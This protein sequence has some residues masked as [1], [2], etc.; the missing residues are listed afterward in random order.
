MF[1][2]CYSEL[3]HVYWTRGQHTVN[4]NTILGHFREQ[5]PRFKSNEQHDV[6]EAIMCIIDI[7]EIQK[8]EI[9]EWFYGKKTQETIWPGGKSSNEEIFSIH[10]IN[11]D[12]ND[13]GKMLS[14]STDWN[15]IE[16]FEDTEG[17]VHHVATSRMVFSKLP[18]V[19][20]LSFDKK[21]HIKSIENLLIDTHEY[22]LVS[23]A[24]HI[25]H[26]HDGHYV[27]FV[28]VRNNWHLIDDNTIKQHDLP[29]EGGFYF[30]VYNLKTPSS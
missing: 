8:P 21:S 28:K 24:V 1:T 5:F 11:S 22:T 14:K 16:N 7:L 20:M 19:L 18:Q 30:M 17:K 10:L 12:G 23:S 13:M 29:D 3:V 25:G 26:Q 4:V 15:T 6:Q 2:K 27:S 9:K